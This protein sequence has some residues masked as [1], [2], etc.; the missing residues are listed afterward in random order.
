M[1]MPSTTT[2]PIQSSAK[3]IASPQQPRHVLYLFDH[4]RNLD[5]G[6]ERSLL[7]ITQLMP[8]DRYR[9][10]IATFCR[11]EDVRF[12]SQFPCPIHTLPLKRSYGWKSLQVARLLRDII[13]CEQVS[14][15]Q[16]FFASSDLWGGAVARLSG[17]PVLISSRRDMGFQ[18]QWK[19]RLG[20]RLMG[21]VYDHVHTVSDAVR[22]YTI[23]QDRVP[24]ANVVSIPN[25]VDLESLTGHFDSGFRARYGLE[26]A[27][28]LIV[29]VGS[30]KAVKGYDVLA[31]VAAIVCQRF[32]R[33]VFVIAGA[34]QDLAYYDLLRELIARL[35]LTLNVRFL[36]HIDPAFS[37][38][39][40]SDVF[41]HLSRTDGLSNSLLEAMAAGL[42]CVL[43]RVGGN[44]EVVEDHGSGFLVSPDDPESSARRVIE[45]LENA[46]VRRKMGARGRELIQERFTADQMVH[47]LME[48]YDSLL[49]AKKGAD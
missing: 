43:T 5:G 37:L 31:R 19:H 44:P 42:P 8:P 9:A 24:P 41:C 7:K 28:H 22:D 25:G 32:P 4:L 38:L 47:Q 39:Q 40:S 11:P 35:G 49:S 20:Y 48:L 36:G 26:D 6:A 13:Q 12:L 34:L 29:D 1:P 16:T 21:R 46:G 15:V 23:R 3:P 18:R 17:V 10:S 14:V 2:L 30:V 33:A 45:L 27:S